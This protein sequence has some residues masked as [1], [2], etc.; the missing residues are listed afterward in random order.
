MM[1]ARRENCIFSNVGLKEAAKREVGTGT[2]QIPDMSFFTY[3][4]SGNAAFVVNLP[5]GIVI[6]GDNFTTD[7]NGY[8]LITMGLALSDYQVLVCEGQSGGWTA[9]GGIY[10]FL[11]VYG[12]NKVNQSQFAVRSAAW[13]SSDKNFIA[14]ST[15]GTWIA[16]GRV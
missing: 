5:G 13:R 15:A 14:S 16:I 9:S 6:Q 8:Q 10:S 11:T 2:G 3:S 1:P 7:S 12:A 4:T